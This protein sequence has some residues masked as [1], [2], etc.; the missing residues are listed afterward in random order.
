M[1]KGVKSG[2]RKAGTP[3]KATS[4]LIL[5]LNRL[6]CDPIR[7]MAQIAMDE[8]NEPALRGKMFAELAQYIH[9]KRKALEHSGPDGGAI[10]LLRVIVE[11]SSA[12]H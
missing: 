1:P 11:D 4:D 7:G 12:K 10:P 3:N 2:G 5:T 8:S 9:P 6:K